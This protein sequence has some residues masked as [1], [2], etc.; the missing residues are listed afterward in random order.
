MKKELLKTSIEKALPSFFMGAGIG[1]STL[2]TIEAVRV[3]PEAYS[4]IYGED[5]SW[6]EKVQRTYKYYIPAGISY[7]ASL[8]CFGLAVKGYTDEAAKF[9][10]AAL[11]ADSRYR[12]Y[13]EQNIKLN[14]TEKD[15]AVRHAM[16][17]QSV[18][19]HPPI[20]P[21]GHNNEFLVYDE[22]TDQYFYATEKEFAHVEREMN[23]I[24]GKESPVRY[25]YLLKMFRN[26]DS[27]K[28]EGELF[29]WFLDDTYSDYHYWNESFFGRP[30]MEIFGDPIE[31]DGEEV[32]V[33]RC[34]VEPLMEAV[35]DPDIYKDAQDLQGL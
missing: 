34:S 18:K 11:V 5:L 3:T 28:S 9:A 1:L 21:I 27:T 2:T 15:E 31:I 12:N 23:R 20:R 29:G 14:G 26:A 16:A 32:Y 7:V 13:R 17:E 25:N 24:L 22:I 4:Q 6:K 10:M 33:L 8:G 30:Y 19:A 35:W